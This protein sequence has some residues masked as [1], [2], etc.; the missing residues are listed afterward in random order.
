[1]RI[2]DWSSDVCSSD[3]PSTLV[4]PASIVAF[5]NTSGQTETVFIAA[6][7]PTDGSDPSSWAL[8]YSVGN[9]LTTRLG[10]ISNR[11]IR[12]ADAVGTSVFFWVGGDLYRYTG[13]GA[14]AEQIGRASCRERVC[15][16]E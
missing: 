13:N 11:T 15:Q 10:D 9:G 6:D 12:D 16:Y 3:L 4:K 14:P 8:Y 1:M 5:Q 2:S 7:Y